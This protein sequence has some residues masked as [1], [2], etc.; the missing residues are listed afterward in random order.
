MARKT[1]VPVPRFEERV[2]RKKTKAHAVHAINPPGTK[3]L[4]AA[5]KAANGVH[6]KDV[7]E[8]LAWLRVFNAK[9]D[10]DARD[11]DA[12]KRV[13]RA[14]TRHARRSLAV[15]VAAMKQVSSNDEEAEPL[16]A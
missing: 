4:L 7:D 13:S 3:R 10:K 5:Y 8:A 12:A 9:G 15:H 6:A 1:V 16:A 2:R 11:R 14:A